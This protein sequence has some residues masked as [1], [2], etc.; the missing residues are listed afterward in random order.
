MPLFLDRWRASLPVADVLPDLKEALAHTAAAVLQAPPGAGKTTLVPLALLDAPWMA[1][2]RILM[3]EPRRLAA[4]AAAQRMAHML[5]E[6]VGATVGYRTRLDS[7]VGRSTRVEVL[8]EGILIRMIEDDPALETAGLVI[9]DEFHE[10]SLDADLGLALTLDARRHLRA[11]LRVLVMSATLEGAAVAGLLQAP[12]IACAGQGRPVSLHYLGRPAPQD[13]EKAVAGAV[14]RALDETD[15]GIL[16]FLPGGAEIRRVERLLRERTDD[17]ALLLAPLYGDLPPERQDEAIRPAPPNCRKIVLATSIAETSLTIE[18]IRVVVDGGLARGPRYEPATGMTSLATTQVSLAAAEQRRGRA[19][20]VAPG[21]CY[22]LWTEREERLFAPFAPPEILQAD[23]APL[24][25]ALAQWGNADAGAYAWLDPPPAAAYAEAQALLRRLGA[26]DGEARITPHGRAMAEFG[27][28]P[29]LAHMVLRGKESGIGRLACA[30]A[31]VLGERDFIRTEPGAS[32]ADLRLRLEAM[33]DPRAET[34]MPGLTVERGTLER[35]RRAARQLRIMAGVK[36]GEM[37]IGEAGRLLAQAYPER[38][39][40]RRPGGSGEFQLAVGRGAY[41]PPA[42]PLAREEFLAVAHLDGER[43]SAR[44]FLA[45]PITRAALEQDFAAAIEAADDIAW[46]AREGA[47]LARRRRRLGELILSDA[48]LPNPPAEKVAAALLAGIRALGLDCLPWQTSSR[49][50]RAR[51]QFL[52]RLQ[53]NGWPDFSDAALLAGLEDWLLPFIAG[54]TRR[55][56]FD[57][58]D[59]DAALGLILSR[60]QRAALDRLAPTHVVV[61]SGSRLSVDYGAREE[62]ALF[63]RLQEIFGARV[64]PAVAEGRVPLLLHLL[65]PA[66]RPLQVTRDIASFWASSYPE[67]RRAMRGRYPR[68]PWPEDPLVAPPTA[69]AKRRPGQA[70]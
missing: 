1:G 59:L 15:G 20:R 39:A 66:G 36:T 49:N 33:L 64:T 5:G 37:P 23:L 34:G 44:I 52:R 61:P 62:P 60:E 13:F 3:L 9:F 53:G 25:L 46:D 63:V 19:G 50:F 24:A 31:A 30:I 47:V 7:R 54:I 56:Q 12:A 69:R 17:P 16:V 58:I 32:D 29:R 21:V 14:L 35:V 10:R 6:E 4:R 26:I 67:V 48:P 40:E 45:A 57:S 41:L 38:I 8:T 51:V 55:A 11:D 65:S 70:G 42:D 28:P 68:H 43:R 22:R 18:D 27:L 2:R